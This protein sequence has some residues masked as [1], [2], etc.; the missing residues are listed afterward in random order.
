M[1]IA[2]VLRYIGEHCG[3]PLSVRSPC[4]QVRLYPPTTFSALFNRYTAAHFRDYLGSV[5]LQKAEALRAGGAGNR[6]SRTA[7]RLFEPEHLLPRPREGKKQAGKG[8]PHPRS[9]ARKIVENDNNIMRGGIDSR[10]ALP[11]TLSTRQ[12]EENLYENRRSCREF[13]SALPRRAARGERR[14]G[15]TRVQMYATHG[16]RARGHDRR[17]DPRR[18]FRTCGRG[19]FRHG[20]VR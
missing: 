18:A 1:F 17:A 13:P 8:S 4:R 10:R 12:K 16:D 5:R 14:R 15:R 7:E 6:R 2:E 19:A 11:Y 9:R 20:A 3:E